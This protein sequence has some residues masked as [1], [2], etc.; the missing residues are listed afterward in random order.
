MVQA[1]RKVNMVFTEGTKFGDTT[2]KQVI[3]EAR[4]QALSQSRDK[5][6]WGP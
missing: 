5:T 6:I 1:G 2:V 4:D 3:A